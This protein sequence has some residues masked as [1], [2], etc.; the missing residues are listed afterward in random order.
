MLRRIV[1]DNRTR[2]YSVVNTLEMW[3]KV[4]EGEELYIFPYQDEANVTFNSA[5]L[6]EL[7]VLKIYVEPLLYSVGAE[8]K[9][10]EEAKRLINMLKVFLP[11][12]PDGIPDDSLLREFI[13][14]SYFNVE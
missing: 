2:N 11:L 14:G 10:Y 9:Y 13:G 12:S 3:S 6:Y 1:R 5:L 4:R 7:S 8:S